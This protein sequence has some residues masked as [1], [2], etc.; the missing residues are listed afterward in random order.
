MIANVERVAQSARRPSGPTGTVLVL[1][2][3][4]DWEGARHARDLADWVGRLGGPVARGSDCLARTVAA[5]LENAVRHCSGGPVRLALCTDA[6]SG[7]FRVQTGNRARAHDLQRLQDR[8]EL[9]RARQASEAYR[10]LLVESAEQGRDVGLGLAR[11][12]CQER[13]RLATRV[14]AGYAQVVAGSRVASFL[15]MTMVEG[16]ANGDVALYLQHPAVSAVGPWEEYAKGLA[17]RVRCGPNDERSEG[18]L[19]VEGDGIDGLVRVRGLWTRG[20][21]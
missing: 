13:V 3:P 2:L 15:P 9:L 1:Q 11:L 21:A 8:V 16:A 12:A 20:E 14:H 7:D 19:T 10:G 18:R 6:P 5:L 17:D 4:A